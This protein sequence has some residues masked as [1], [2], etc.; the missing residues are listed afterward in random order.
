[1]TSWDWWA[2]DSSDRWIKKKKDNVTLFSKRDVYGVSH[3]G[4]NSFDSLACQVNLW[5]DA[6]VPKEGNKHISIR[7]SSFYITA[8]SD[9]LVHWKTDER[10]GH[11]EHPEKTKRTPPQKKAPCPHTQRSMNHVGSVVFHRMH[12]CQGIQCGKSAAILCLAR[13]AGLACL[14]FQQTRVSLS[15]A[16]STGR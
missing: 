4:V 13:H 5:R 8:D 2:M 12:R 15:G 10:R 16:C 3:T 14:K 11:K 6:K 9:H 7:P 1:M